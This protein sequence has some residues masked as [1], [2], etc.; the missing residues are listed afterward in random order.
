MEKEK[1]KKE[2]ENEAKSA[3]VTFSIV[4]CLF[5]LICGVIVFVIDPF[6]HYHKPV[7]PLKAVI[8]K[9]E[10]QCVGSIRHLDYD[11]LI[12]GSSVAENYNNRWFDEL[13]EVKSIKGIQKSAETVDLL[14]YLNEAKKNHTLRKVFYSLDLPALC[15][16]PDKTFPNPNMPDFLFDENLWN[17]GLY[18]LN[19]DVLL[20]D[21]PYMIA[22]SII[23]NYDEG[24]SYNWWQYKNFSKEGAVLQYRY[25]YLWE[26]QPKVSNKTYQPVVDANISSLVQA[27]RENPDTEFY[28]L[29]PP[30]S[31]MRW[32]E[33]ARGGV[34]EEYFYALRQSMEQLLECENAKLYY[35][36]ND[37]EIICNLD[38]YM[39]TVHFSKEIN[40]YMVNEMAEGN[41]QLTKENYE[42]ELEK[43][44]CLIEDILKNRRNEFI[45]K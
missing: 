20:E 34:M 4:T 9:P 1:E 23:G 31:M 37:E 44:G 17:D 40:A 35:F 15:A 41:Y 36:Q 45:P 8:T 10:Y 21:I 30:Y 7:G 24:E 29:Y 6:F 13:F 39:D 27:V 16:D 38:H 28:F 12:L 25:T 3:L 42:S 2:A 43:M 26:E 18:L 5:L 22:M 32:D 14:Y 33:V 19:K 11:A